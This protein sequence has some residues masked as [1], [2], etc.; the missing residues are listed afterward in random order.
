MLFIL[1]IFRNTHNY[2]HQLHQNFYF[3]LSNCNLHIDSQSFFA[4]GHLLWSFLCLLLSVVLRKWIS[5]SQLQ[6]KCY[7]T[8]EVAGNF[9]EHFSRDFL[10]SSYDFIFYFTEEIENIKSWLQY[11]HNKAIEQARQAIISII[12]H[13]INAV[14]SP[15]VNNL[16]ATVKFAI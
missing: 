7:V 5:H 6:W 3:S 13:L 11:I 1:R 14:P 10:P 4:F 15:N 12:D 9:L 8:A 2:P 16:Q